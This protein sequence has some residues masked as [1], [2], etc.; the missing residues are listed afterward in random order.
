MAGVGMRAQAPRPVPRA[1]DG[2]RPAAERPRA[3]RTPGV[4]PV[5]AGAVRAAAALA[6]ASGRG[7]VLA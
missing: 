3:V 7:L 5:G 6:A 4:D 1:G 2:A